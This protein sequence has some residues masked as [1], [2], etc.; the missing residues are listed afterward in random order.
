MKVDEPKTSCEIN[1]NDIAKEFKGD[2]KL[3]S[4]LELYKNKYVAG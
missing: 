3:V 2:A 4:T 1:E